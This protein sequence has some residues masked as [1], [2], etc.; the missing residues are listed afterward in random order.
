MTR[1]GPPLIDVTSPRF[2]GLRHARDSLPAWADL[3]TG[4][5]AA[6]AEPPLAGRICRHVARWQGAGAG[7]VARS[8]LHALMDVLGELPQPGTWSRS[9]S[10][11][12]RS[13]SGPP[14]GRPEEES[15]CAGTRTTGRAGPARRRPAVY[16]G[17]R[18]VPGVQPAG[19]T[20]RAATACGLR[21]R[22]ARRRRLARVR[23]GGRRR[24]YA[25]LVRGRSRRAG[26]GG[27]DGEGVRR[28]ARSTHRRPGCRRRPGARRRQRG[29]QQ[30]A[31]GGRSRGGG[32][33][34][35]A[36]R[37]RAA[38]CGG[39]GP[40][41]AARALPAGDAGNCRDPDRRAA[42]PLPVAAPGDC[43]PGSPVAE[44]AAGQRDPGGPP[45]A[46]LPAGGSRSASCCGPTTPRRTSSASRRRCAA[47]PGRRRRRRPPC[48]AGGSG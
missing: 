26:L 35:G 24:G 32:E 42:V 46:A 40:G 33:R 30:P 28:P 9:T 23:G 5:P 17:R 7:L 11:P 31:V 47:W 29:T 13:P 8:S 43:R 10:S 16:H 18:M 44:P 39:P 3:T 34:A 20:G 1:P 41:D 37:S 2:L 19:A 22:P 14:C 4:V 27:V 38:G 15:R 12:T 36:R 21:G 45:A 6:L 48:A 25:G